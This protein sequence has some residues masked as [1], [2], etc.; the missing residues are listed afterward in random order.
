MRSSEFSERQGSAIRRKHESKNYPR[1]FT[2]RPIVSEILLCFPSSSL[3]IITH[4]NRRD[5]FTIFS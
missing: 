4:K 1:D 3:K 5:N 2:I